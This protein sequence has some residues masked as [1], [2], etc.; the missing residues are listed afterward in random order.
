MLRSSSLSTTA[1]RA[2]SRRDAGH[3][4]AAIVEHQPHAQR[5]VPRD[6]KLADAASIADHGNEYLGFRREEKWQ[7]VLSVNPWAERPLQDALRTMNRFEAD[8]GRWAFRE[9]KRF[10]DIIGLPDPIKCRCRRLGRGWSALAAASSVLTHGRTGRNS[11][12]ARA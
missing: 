2:A 3:D 7:P 4:A 11:H 8:N 10:A 12:S 1:K 5:A 6:G 9:G